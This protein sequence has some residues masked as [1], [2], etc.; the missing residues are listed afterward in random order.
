MLL[1]A[2]DPTTY[3]DTGYLSFL[4]V[5]VLHISNIKCYFMGNSSV[6]CFIL[7][8]STFFTI[9]I[10]LYCRSSDLR[11]VLL[12]PHILNTLLVLF[13]N[14]IRYHHVLLLTHMCV[15]SGYCRVGE[16]PAV[17]DGHLL[18]L[19]TIADNEDTNK[20]HQYRYHLGNVSMLC[21][22][23]CVCTYMCRMY[24]YVCVSVCTCVCTCLCGVRVYVDLH[25]FAYKLC[26]P[27]TFTFN[28]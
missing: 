1:A 11:N 9:S 21:V 19:L 18:S 10:L 20:I 22:C 14:L 13:Y 7:G 12:W 4:V 15:T 24:L 26:Y 16:C 2:C 25:N 6:S 8:S 27:T 17:F 3:I 23:L 28:P 5:N